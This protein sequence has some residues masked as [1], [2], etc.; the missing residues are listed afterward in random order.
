MKVLVSGSSG[1]VGSALVSSFAA[2]G[3]QIVRLVRAVAARADE[4]EWHPTEGTIDASAL[5]GL[6]A[7]VHLAGENIASRRWSERQ[8]ARIRTSRVHSTR[9]LCDALAKRESP[10]KVLICASAI[11]YYGDRGDETL[12]ET[13]T[14]G[15]SFLSE[16]C[17]NWE[18][19]TESARAKGIRVVHLRFGVVLSAAGG[20]L[21][22]MLLPFKLGLGGIVG[23]GQQYWSWIDLN[24]VVGVISHSLTHE[25]LSGPVNAV[26]PNPASN[27]DFTKALGRVL[28]RPTIFPIPA[29]AARILLGE[30]AD[31]LLLASARVVPT[32]LKKSGFEFQYPNLED[33]L[34]HAVE[35]TTRI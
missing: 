23:S 8:K 14:M 32:A 20:A 26:S 5:E 21:A 18:A 16:I 22:K 15:T 35:R 12:D 30:M 24:D 7:V 6:D 11:G 4:I 33:A 34:K 29:F 13:S 27:R 2:D 1:L 25:Q 10:P 28:R 3:R 17:Q 31:E 9:L 19:A